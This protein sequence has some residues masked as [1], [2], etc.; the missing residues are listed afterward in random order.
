MRMAL[1]RGLRGGW[2]LDLT[3]VDPDDGKPWDLSLGAKRRKVMEMLKRDKPMLLIVSPM[4]GAFSALQ[5]LFNYPRMDRKEVMAKLKDGLSH[6]K[7]AME[8]CVMQHNAGRLFMFEHPET[9]SSWSTKA[10]QNLARVQGVYKVAFDFCMMGMLTKGPDG[11][12]HPAKKRTGILTN[13]QAIA[14]ALRRAQ[15]DGKHVHVPLLGGGLAG[16]CQIYPDKFCRLVCDG[17]KEELARSR[18]RNQMAKTYD[19]TGQFGELMRLEELQ[20]VPEEVPDLSH[21]YDGQEFVDDISGMPLDKK[22]AIKARILEM[23]FFRKKGVYSKVKRQPW[24]N[25]ITTKWI[26]QNK[27][28]SLNPNYRARLVGREIAYDKR[29]HLFAA[30]P[31][32]ESLRIIISRCASNQGNRRAELNFIVMSNDVKRAYFEAPGEP[33]ALHPHP[34]GG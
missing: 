1:K 31:P 20:T 13:S 12:Q 9:A 26:D 3:M 11:E 16:P 30:T 34:E 18:W 5:E 22:Q 2:S 6:L 23:E 7:F 24:M 27:G 8:L 17:L 4:C 28:D 15:C 14:S 19:V 32:L 25:V 21:L 10:V 33:R 29:E